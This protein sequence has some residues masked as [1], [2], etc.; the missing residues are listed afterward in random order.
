MATSDMVNGMSFYPRNRLALILSTTAFGVLLLILFALITTNRIGVSVTGVARSSRTVSGGFIS[1]TEYYAYC[2]NDLLIV[3]DHESKIICQERIKYYPK[4]VYTNSLKSQIVI[5]DADRCDV[6]Q[7]G[8]VRLGLVHIM[9]I[10]FSD[11]CLRDANV[12]SFN[13]TIATVAG[14]TADNIEALYLISTSD[15]AFR[16]LCTSLDIP[17]PFRTTRKGYS[18]SVCAVNTTGSECAFVF[19]TRLFRMNMINN[20]IV[21]GG[22]HGI[23]QMRYSATN[24]IYAQLGSALV[25]VGDEGETR[26]IYTGNAESATIKSYCVNS[27]YIYILTETAKNRC[28]ILQLDTKEYILRG[29]H[30]V[31]HSK[32]VYCSSSD[33]L[34]N[35]LTD[36][37]VVVMLKF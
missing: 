1:D 32:A 29:R 10:V 9:S 28:S 14:T 16:Q 6:Y 35:Y 3:I 18:F 20:N 27:K 36:D 17:E 24:K 13:G 30:N 8:E 33:N 25:R 11:Y 19:N 4:Y 34:I 7:L 21:D 15:Q 31:V 37:G 12:T 5:G 2:T 26:F 23:Q 22:I